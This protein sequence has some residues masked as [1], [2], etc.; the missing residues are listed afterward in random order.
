[1]FKKTTKFKRY[2]KGITRFILN[3]KKY[4]LRKKRTSFQFQ[5]NLVFFWTQFYGVIRG[6]ARFTQSLNLLRYNLTLSNGAFVKKVA[7]KHF[8]TGASNTSKTESFLNFTTIKKAIYWNRS[9][10]ILSGYRN[11]NLTFQNTL[12]GFMSAN[13]IVKKG[14]ESSTFGLVTNLKTH[15]I[16]DD[17]F[18][19]PKSL[20]SWSFLQKRILTLTLH[21]VKSIRKTMVLLILILYMKP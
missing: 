21:I 20:V 6:H 14:Y 8:L 5:S 9:L 11:K 4:I 19:T 18:L 1:M 16:T 17:S 7:Q 3:R 10:Y 2:N 15:F 13:N 12:I